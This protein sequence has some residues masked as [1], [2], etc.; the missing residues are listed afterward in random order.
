[1]V[2]SQLLIKIYRNF[3][4]LAQHMCHVYIL[5]LAHAS[6]QAIFRHGIEIYS[7]KLNFS[8]NKWSRQNPKNLELSSIL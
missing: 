3:Q 7:L 1:M 8:S 2:S 5:I 4:L 6:Q